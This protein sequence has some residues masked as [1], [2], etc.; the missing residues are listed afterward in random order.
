[1]GPVRFI[2]S[3]WLGDDPRHRGFHWLAFYPERYTND[4][5]FTIHGRESGNKYKHGFRIVSIRK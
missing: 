1:M 3:P 2:K 4:R 5:C